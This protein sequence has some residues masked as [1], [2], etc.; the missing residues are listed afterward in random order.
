MVD[1]LRERAQEPST[2]RGLA[3]LLAVVGIPQAEGI[4]QHASIIVVSGIGLFDTIRKG[5]KFGQKP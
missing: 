5:S 2:W 3:L 4:V 1:W